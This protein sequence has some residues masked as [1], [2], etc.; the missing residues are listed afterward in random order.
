M[1]S[2]SEFQTYEDMEDLLSSQGEEPQTTLLY[3]LSVL[4][5]KVQQLQSL[6][7]LIISPI[8][9]EK[10]TSASIAFS[11][12]QTLA[13]EIIVV[14]SAS[15]N[16]LKHLNDLTF[17]APSNNLNDSYEVIS[18]SEAIDNAFHNIPFDS[19]THYKDDTDKNFRDTGPL[20]QDNSSITCDIVEL[21]AADLL[22]KYTHYCHVC[23]KGFKRDANLRMHMRAHGDEYKSNEALSNPM[24]SGC[25]EDYNMNTIRKYSCPQAGCRWNKKHAKFQPLKSM[26]CAKNHYK[27]SHCPKMYICNRCNRKQFSVLSDLRTHEKHCGDIRWRCSCGTTF[28]RKDKLIGHVSLFI[29]HSPVTNSTN[30]KQIV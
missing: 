28:S 16:V 12:A 6:V 4:K 30:G 3:N 10:E 20:P 14:A 17:M 26:I 13:Q 5:E 11:G 9:T 7:T 23:G 19:V 1:I 15:M 21:E 24:K 22:A 27:R 18:Q 8:E 29:G 2:D 25:S